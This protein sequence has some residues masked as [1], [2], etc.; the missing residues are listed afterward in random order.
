MTNAILKRLPITWIKEI[1]DLTIE[2]IVVVDREGIILFI[3]STYCE[4]LDVKQEFAIG[5]PVQQVIENTRMHIV[6]TT[7]KEELEGLQPINGSVMIANRYPLIID[8][9]LVGALGTVKYPGPDNLRQS[10]N[11]IQDLIDELNFY[12]TKAQ[13]ELQSKYNFADLT[14]S[15]P[16]FLAAKKLAEKVSGSNSSVLLTGESGTGKE[17]FAHAIH[18]SSMRSEHPFVALNCASIP[19]DLFESELFGYEDGAFT[20]A[21]KGG[22]K[23][24]LHL[25]NDGTIF[26]DEIG[27]MPLSM[28]SKLLRT[29]QE[30]EINPVGGQS[31]IPI[32]LR[33]I[34]ATNQD[35]MKMVDEGKFRKDLFYRL[36]VINIEIPPLRERKEDIAPISIKI[37]EKLE[38]NFYRSGTLLSSE[39]IERFKHHSWPGNVRELENVL[40]RAINVLDGRTIELSHLP[41]YLR[42][43]ETV[44]SRGGSSVTNPPK[45]AELLQV[46][47][48]KKTIAK[49]EKQE[50][51]NALIFTNGNKI[52]AAKLLGLGKTNLYDKCKK[53]EIK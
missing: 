47:P 32:N 1:I 53:Y 33:V 22:K 11:K 51:K 21:K 30:N 41:L 49:V 3:N 29:L 23:G 52:E 14:G 16:I 46:S 28:Q 15:S 50:I 12:K 37:L 26:L 2:R 20:G 24:Q 18:H 7:G 34:A 6:A 42:D 31:T 27:D 25:A 13:K 19:Q 39:V 48:L 10:K 4:F 36:N 43:P 9:E 45:D 8:N 35:L 5:K 44:A 17:L 40:E 38:R